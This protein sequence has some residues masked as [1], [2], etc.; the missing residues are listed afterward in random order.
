MDK[1]CKNYIK[2]YVPIEGED[3]FGQ[4]SLS[5]PPV[6]KRIKEKLEKDTVEFIHLK[7]SLMLYQL[8]CESIRDNKNI[9][10]M[11]FTKEIQANP[12]ISLSVKYLKKTFNED[13]YDAPK[14]FC[15][16]YN[17]F[18]TDYEGYSNAIKELE[19][20]RSE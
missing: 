7:Y 20:L 13:V 19:I 12:F 10:Y 3:E 4:Y 2:N 6:P 11:L 14:G 17:K 16:T 18:V 15:G 8:H 1:M 5:F 9:D